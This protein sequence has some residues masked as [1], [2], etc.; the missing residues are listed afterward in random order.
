MAGL[1]AVDNCSMAALQLQQQRLQRL[2]G[3]LKR[4][5]Q[6]YALRGDEL[7]VLVAAAGVAVLFDAC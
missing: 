4:A 3:S 5:V 7:Q 6:P 2:Q 1:E